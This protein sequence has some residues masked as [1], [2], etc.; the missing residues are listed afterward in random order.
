VV[1]TERPPIVFY[2]FDLL[3]LDGKDLRQLPVEKRKSQLER[4]LEKAPENIR[5]SP[6]FEHDVKE[7][8]AKAKE[9][10]LEG[11]IAK[12]RGSRY[13]SGK[14]E[15]SLDQDQA[16]PGTRVRDWLRLLRLRVTSRYS[17]VNTQAGALEPGCVQ[18]L[19]FYEG[20]EGPIRKSIYGAPIT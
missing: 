16:A 2:A 11:L 18:A 19:L 15:R 6:S 17:R 3:Q 14:R 1:A 7:L 9:F 12:R 4:L 20:V 10:E 5:F 13:E 8:L